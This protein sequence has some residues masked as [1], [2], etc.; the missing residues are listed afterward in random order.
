MMWSFSYYPQVKGETN[1]K[2]FIT[3]SPKVLDEVYQ[4][5]LKAD[6]SAVVARANTLQTANIN[7]DLSD[8]E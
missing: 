1:M 5:C 2:F 3:S 4:A 8:L 6:E 7:L